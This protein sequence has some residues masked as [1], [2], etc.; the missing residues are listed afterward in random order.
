MILGWK[1]KSPSVNASRDEQAGQYHV[2]LFMLGTSDFAVTLT[3]Y[4][5][6][7]ITK[8]SSDVNSLPSQFFV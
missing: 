6:C 8:A 1:M 2:N 3:T 4:H 7:E 5:Y